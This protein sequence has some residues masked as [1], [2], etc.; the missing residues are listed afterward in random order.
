MDKHPGWISG[1]ATSRSILGD[2]I[3]TPLPTEFEPVPAG[4]YLAQPDTLTLF[5][6]NERFASPAA[7]AFDLTH[8]EKLDDGSVW[9]RYNVT[10][11]TQ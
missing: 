1:A 2:A 6:S 9:L 10:G 3:N 5:E 11:P 7:Y 8:V 4:D